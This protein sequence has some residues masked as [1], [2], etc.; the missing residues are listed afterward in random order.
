[1]VRKQEKVI[2]KIIIIESYGNDIDYIIK[3]SLL[4]N[5]PEQKNDNRGGHN[6]EIILLT[7]ECFKKLCIKSGT[8]KLI[9]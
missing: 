4:R 8:K 2:F 9:K 7:T 3:K 1:M 6:K 5:I